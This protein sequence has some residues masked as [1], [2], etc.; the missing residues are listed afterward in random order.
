MNEQRWQLATTAQVEA[1]EE[2]SVVYDHATDQVLCL[3]GA[4]SDVLRA[5]DANTVE[6]I[7][8]TTGIDAHEVAA[9]LIELSD[10]GLVAPVASEPTI[11]RRSLVAAAGGTVAALGLW[12][13]AAPSAAAAASGDVTTV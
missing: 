1:L 6:E 11:A 12:S 3:S 7:A 5:I 8:S 4:S 10:R 13:I 9:Q 2:G